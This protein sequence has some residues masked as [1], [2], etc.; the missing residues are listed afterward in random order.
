MKDQS[1][2]S[3]Q[4]ELH[5]APKIKDSVVMTRLN[6]HVCDSSSNETFYIMMHSTQF[7]YGYMAE[8]SSNK[9]SVILFRIVHIT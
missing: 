2:D 9:V 5:F 7:T 3:S 8:A 6:I 4:H 1:D